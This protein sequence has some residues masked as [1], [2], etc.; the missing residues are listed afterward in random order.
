MSPETETLSRAEQVRRRRAEESKLR[1]DATKNRVIG[2]RK[3]TPPAKKTDLR[4]PTERPMLSRAPI[5][6]S[7]AQR[8]AF[9]AAS[10]VRRY[11]AA[12]SM[13]IAR[14]AAKPAMVPI[15]IGNRWVSGLLALAS[16]A[17]MVWMLTMP[18]FVFTSVQLVGAQRVSPL[19]V[20]AA[21]NLVGRSILFANPQEIEASVRAAFPEFLDV[22]VAIN[23]PAEVTLTVRERTPVVAWQYQDRLTWIDADGVAFTPRGAADNVAPVMAFGLPPSQVQNFDPLNLDKTSLRFI[24]PETVLA[25]QSLQPYVP[26]GAML[27]YEPEYGLGWDDPRGWRVFFGVTGRDIPLKL[28]IYQTIV[29]TLLQR[30]IIPTMISVAY[31]DAPFYRTEP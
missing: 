20:N 24:A 3:A 22:K 16:L 31:P 14:G 13:P 21:T 26:A 12:Y 11:N 28:Q 9:G 25:I 4:K 5:R 2:G 23:I 29:D 17:L 18:P 15:E 30:G 27:I 8:A 19:E 7:T 10:N 1:I 6:S